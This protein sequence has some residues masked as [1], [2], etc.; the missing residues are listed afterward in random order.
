MDAM[1]YKQSSAALRGFN[2]QPILG[3]YIDPTIVSS[4]PVFLDALYI[5]GERMTDTLPVVDTTT[6]GEDGNGDR[7]RLGR[8]DVAAE[9]VPLLRRSELLA[10]KPKLWEPSAGVHDNL[11]AAR[12]ISVALVMV[13]PF[14]CAIAM[15]VW[16]LVRH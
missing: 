10:P 1:P 14:W 16:W 6:A 4:R 5:N 3:I 11:D 15:G 2:K 13:T 8:T 12:G 9:L 7:R